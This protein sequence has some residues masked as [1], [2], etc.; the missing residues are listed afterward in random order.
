MLKSGFG[1]EERLMKHVCCQAL[2]MCALHAG[3]SA[4]APPDFA[5]E[6]APLLRE[7]CVKCHGPEKQKGGLRFDVKSHAIKKGDTGEHSIVPG[8]SAES[9]LVRRITSS[10]KDVRMPS[11]GEPLTA[12]QVELLKAWIDAGAAWPDDGKPTTKGELVVT[13]QDRQHWSFRP[14]ASPQPPDIAFNSEIDKFVVAS[15]TKAGLKLSGPAS[16][17][18]LVR[19][20][21]FDLIGLPPRR[22]EIAEFEAAHQQDSFAAVAALVDRL[23]AT[24][25][26]GERWGRHWLDVARYADSDGQESD[27]DRPF[28]YQYRDYVIR[29][30]NDD[31]P[32]DEFI[33]WQIAGDELAPDNPLANAATGFLIAGPHAKLDTIEM[34]D[35]KLRNRYDELDD[36]I[37]TLGSS[38]LGLTLACTRCHDHKY[39]A[40]PTRDYYRLMAAFHSGKRQDVLLGSRAD[41]KKY[42]ESRQAWEKSLLQAEQ[43]L[44]AWLDPERKPLEAQLRADKIATLKASDEEKAT[45]RDQPDS[46]AGKKLAKK[47]EKALAI[48][49][50][51]LK[52]A[53]S[54]DQRRKW[55]ELAAAVNQAKQAQPAAPPKAFAFRDEAAEPK[56]TW[57]FHR[58]NYYDKS[59]PVQFGFLTVLTSA[60]SPEAY[61][62]ETKS[63]REV[64]GSTY[65]RAALAKWIT[66]IE[67]G[68]GAL[69][70]RVIVNRV[71]RHHFGDGLVRTPSDFGVQGERPSH[72]EL[73]EWLTHDFVA[74]G[75][76]LKRL[77][78]QIVLSQVYQQDSKFSEA[79][80]KID[81]ENRLLW[82]RRPIRLEAEALRDAMLVCAGTMNREPFGP[83]FKP[84]IATEAMVAR[85]LKS[86]YNAE[87]PDSPNIRRRSVYMFHKRVVPYP[88]LQTFDRPDALQSCSRRDTTTVAPQALAILNDQFVRDRAVELSDR[89]RKETDG[90][91]DSAVRSAFAISLARNPS[92]SELKSSTEFI[93]SRQAE[94]QKRGMSERDAQRAALADFCQTMFGLNEFLYVD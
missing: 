77:H 16:A 82:R 6:I 46:E 45:L 93:A 20:I 85:N 74:S 84:P 54:D 21:Y 36:T 62:S 92:E 94:R 9:E 56:P 44:K 2:V 10:D 83:G 18:T 65:Q 26:Y 53:M 57:L 32:Y 78:R 90:D 66:D 14:L 89:L 73:L 17:R 41:L 80:A 35:E 8:K 79:A 60:K 71:W 72:P 19:R 30:L 59:E 47:H 48:S 68:A 12:A 76:K 55:D 5:K 13:E 27:S 64:E 15:L 1:I 25:H 29:S 49:N 39:D 70:A 42:E 3:L 40:I 28:A 52:R 87:P 37:A 88:L 23:L 34:E 22:E 75:W 31:L 11:E 63:Q 4:A 91:L 81:A 38:M 61:W 51:D 33:R 50:D 67:Q 24:T 69:L 7:H 43:A 86:P 58:A